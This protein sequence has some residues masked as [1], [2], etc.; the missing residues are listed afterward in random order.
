MRVTHATRRRR[1]RERYDAVGAP[2][3]I[4]ER[5][6]PVQEPDTMPMRAVRLDPDGPRVS[7]GTYTDAGGRGGVNEDAVLLA[8]YPGEMGIGLLVGVAD[9][10][11]GLQAGE[12][13]S[14]MA[15]ERI[16]QS[17]RSFP[18][19]AGPSLEAFLQG[20]VGMASAD[21][22]AYARS[23]PGIH[24][25]G[26]T[27]VLTAI[28]RGEALVA[29]VGDSRAYLVRAG[30]VYPLTDDHTAAR[31]S[32]LAGYTPASS[33]GCNLSPH[34]LT[35]CLG[36][37]GDS[38]CAFAPP[39]GRRFAVLDGDVLFLCTDGVHGAMDEGQLLATLNRT[40]DIG[41]FAREVCQRAVAAGS[42]D[43][44]TCVAV[45]VGRYRGRRRLPLPLS[46]WG[47]SAPARTARTPGAVCRRVWALVVVLSCCMA[48]SL[49]AGYRLY[50]GEW[51]RGAEA[52]LSVAGESDEP[53]D[54][55]E[56]ERVRTADPH[57]PSPVEARSAPAPPGATAASPSDAEAR[58][59]SLIEQQARDLDAGVPHAP[60]GAMPRQPRGTTRSAPRPGGGGR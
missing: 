55:L 47:R 19:H 48:G 44:V 34:A 18:A 25:M 14:R 37:E 39:P 51:G 49:A 31:E 60:R 32:A 30:Q 53:G 15:L 20:A 4:A 58:R 33:G 24:D 36:P 40:R 26:S 10:M 5:A 2:D 52:A 3:W 29:H 38:R 50:H 12:V 28:A 8:R 35:R 16:A 46:R 9:G 22:T 57:P 6:R 21:I 17:A 45:E 43:N 27:V 41:A 1:R 42:N 13:A 23:T 59:L 54:R 56:S 7:V 11:G